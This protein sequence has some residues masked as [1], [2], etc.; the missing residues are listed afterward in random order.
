MLFYSGASRREIDVAHHAWSYT[1]VS[2]QTI[3][4]DRSARPRERAGRLRIGYLSPNF[5]KGASGRHSLP[6][7]VF[8]DDK[9]FELFGYH[10]GPRDDMTM[11]FET[12]SENWRWLPHAGDNE[13]AQ[14]IADDRIDV[15][16]EL[17]G[18][19][20]GNRLQALRAQPARFHLTA[21]DYPCHP[22]TPAIQ[23]YLGASCAHRGEPDWLPYEGAYLASMGS[24]VHLR[25]AR[26][27]SSRFFGAFTRPGKLHDHTLHLWGRVL[28][29]TPGFGLILKM[30]GL[31]DSAFVDHLMT[32]MDNCGLDSSRVIFD[33]QEG[34]EDYLRSFGRVCAILD[35]T[36]Y[37]NGATSYD[38]LSM[39]CPIVSLH[40]DT[41]VNQATAAILE[42]A[43]HSEL[44]AASEEDYVAIAARF[45][46]DPAWCNVE[47]V[48]AML[49]E[50]ARLHVRELERIY[51]EVSE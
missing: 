37:G 50:L 23:G 26:N 6:L 30:S 39:G 10:V 22:G 31:E 47:D 20:N 21:V 9:N 41:Y 17:S 51:T 5:R 25:S 14:L 16:V 49:P 44:I 13:L 35:S 8:H 18:H 4:R 43:N 40:S 1:Q 34:Y 19:T 46:L 11:S 3:M 48:N 32:R 15:L 29:A 7:F 24:R 28:R 36:P 33:P 45:A 38:A 42:A 27:L 12:Y 2:P